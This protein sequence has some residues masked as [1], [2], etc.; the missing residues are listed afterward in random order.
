MPEKKIL[1]K[2]DLWS[3]TI[4]FAVMTLSCL[5]YLG[6]RLA[7][8]EAGEAFALGL[9]ALI[10]LVL[11][12]FCAFTDRGE[13][14]RRETEEPPEASKRWA[15]KLSDELEAQAWE[16]AG[17]NPKNSPRAQDAMRKDPPPIG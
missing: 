15:A 17:I 16:E 12:L 9:V 13:A 2:S 8:G 7:K 4:A 3:F 11:T 1:W 10:P 6:V 14:M 5:A